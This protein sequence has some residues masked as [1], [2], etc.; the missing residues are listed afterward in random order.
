MKTIYK[1]QRM[2]F[3]IVIITSSISAICLGLF[4]IQ[5][6]SIFDLIRHSNQ[7]YYGK[8]IFCALV[9]F[10]WVICSISY[11]YAKTI[12]GKNIILEVKK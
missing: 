6:G 11:E 12:Y 9:L 5:L 2:I 10:V 7:E 3:T 8:I 1:K 4:S